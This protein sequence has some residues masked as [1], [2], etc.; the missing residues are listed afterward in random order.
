MPILCSFQGS[1]FPFL[2][3]IR[4]FFWV[5]CLIF[6]G[7]KGFLVAEFHSKRFGFRW[8]LF[9]FL[10]HLLHY[11]FRIKWRG[12]HFLGRP[13]QCQFDA[14]R[15]VLEVSQRVAGISS[16]YQ[17]GGTFTTMVALRNLI[18]IELQFPFK[19]WSM[20]HNCDDLKVYVSC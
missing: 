3:K 18:R 6:S 17:F 1:Q 5:S 19:L 7:F 13:L 16:R 20:F 11:G 14:L 2:L 8:F 15:I 12:T 10:F 9:N 4:T